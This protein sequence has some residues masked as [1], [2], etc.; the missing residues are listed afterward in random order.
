[1]RRDCKPSGVLRTN[2]TVAEQSDQSPVPRAEQVS[3][4]DRAR[5]VARGLGLDV[6]LVCAEATGV[7]RTLES[8][9]DQASK[10]IGEVHFRLGSGR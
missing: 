3:R 8:A 9:T 4:T 1:M 6:A 10:L 5:V 7:R 2:A